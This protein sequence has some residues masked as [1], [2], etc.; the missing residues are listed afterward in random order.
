MKKCK[1][2]GKDGIIWLDV[3]HSYCAYNPS[4]EKCETCW[5]MENGECIKGHS[6]EEI[7]E[8]KD[9][10]ELEELGFDCLD[11]RGEQ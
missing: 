10:E 9:N 7:E 6:S 5:N 4:N 2:C 8:M 3:H 1:Y 11:W